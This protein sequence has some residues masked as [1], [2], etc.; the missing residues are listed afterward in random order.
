LLSSESESGIGSWLVL[1]NASVHTAIAIALRS[2]RNLRYPSQNNFQKMAKS[3]SR[4]S[5]NVQPV[6]EP[7]PSPKAPSVSPSS[8]SLEDASNISEIQREAY[9]HSASHP[10]SPTQSGVLDTEDSVT[11]QWEDCGKVFTHLPTLIH[12]I[13]NGKFQLVLG[14]MPSVAEVK[15]RDGQHLGDRAGLL[16]SLI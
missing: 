14:C 5:K 10:G 4:R 12:H 13:H 8:S 6:Q 11:C 3:S 9:A 16:C 7:K 15:R 2:L 1:D